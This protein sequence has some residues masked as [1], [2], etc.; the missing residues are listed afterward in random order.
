LACDIDVI[1]AVVPGSK[2]ADGEAT[3]DAVAEERLGDVALV[4]LADGAGSARRG[5]YGARLAVQSAVE[6]LQERLAAAAEPLEDALG[7]AIEAARLTLSVVAG[8]A[9]EGGK[10]AD[11]K[12]LA[13]TLT[14]AVFGNQ[15]VGVASIGDGVHILRDVRG[16]LSFIAMADDTEIANHTDFVTSPAMREKVQV[17]VRPAA[18][19]E[20]LL[21]SSD[22][23]DS[24]L[25]GRAKEA[26]WP[27]ATAGSLLNAPVL[28]GWDGSDFE[29]LLTSSVIRQQSDD[30]CS[31]ILV[32]RLFRPGDSSIE[33]GG[34]T[35]TPWGQRG[36][37]RRVWRVRGCADLVAIELSEQAAGGSHI[38]RRR[39]QVWDRGRRYPPVCWPIRRLDEAMVLLP[40]T[41]TG[42]KNV[43]ELFAPAAAE[44]R[45]EM[46]RGVAECV[47]A[48][49]AAGVAHGALELNCF[50][51]YPDGSFGLWDPGP[52]MFEEAD[53]ATCRRRDQEFLARI[54]GAGVTGPRTQE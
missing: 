53:L 25:V 24:Q 52:G 16:E 34:L 35:L 12:E 9:D 21:L 50:T 54:E 7:A 51:R 8:T 41:P 45:A 38:C 14:V 18:D 29:R 48:V 46:A 36:S 31:L 6:S 26:R 40:R 44:E 37:G 13:T 20:S 42:S 11:L 23:L 3:E 28:D 19:V 4:A 30:D 15:Q 2:R 49:H 43:A 33:V 39:E 47:E 17:A 22:G 1:T 10:K 5:G 27:L 32:R